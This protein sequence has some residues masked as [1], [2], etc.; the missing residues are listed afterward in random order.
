LALAF[1]PPEADVMRRPPRSREEPIL[2]RYLIWR[3]VYVS[4]VMGGLTLLLFFTMLE[5]YG[6]L[7]LARA[8]AVNTLV[9]GELAYLLNTRFLIASPLMRRHLFSN[10]AIFVSI[11]LLVLF[12]M[13]FTY[14]PAMQ[15]W[16]GVAGLTLEHWGYV[17]LAGLTVF[18]VVEFE[19]WV[20]R[21]GANGKPRV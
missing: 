21:V 7:D 14:T 4:V 3:V 20:V 18:V 13:L 2:S 16:F 8:I 19:K 9:A 17:L 12:Q 5:R 10:P 15:L 11:G 1:E 6:D